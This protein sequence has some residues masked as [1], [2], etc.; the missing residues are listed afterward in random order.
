MVMTPDDQRMSEAFLCTFADVKR[1]TRLGWADQ[2][3][4]RRR[5][6]EEY[7]VR[8]L[9]ELVACRLL[10]AAL[11]S[12]EGADAWRQVRE[13]FARRLP[14]PRLD[15]VFSEADHRADLVT[16]DSGL[17]GLIRHGRL[18]R[19]VQLAPE[20]NRA[21]EAFARYRAAREEEA[22]AKGDAN[23]KTARVPRQLDE[24]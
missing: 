7:T 14:G 16:D 3:L 2:G 9:H 5:K 18:V 6:G 4:L 20:M 22:A 19:V 13:D 12:A 23:P 21:R 8:D 10:K 24:A 15:V 11:G 1:T 17:A